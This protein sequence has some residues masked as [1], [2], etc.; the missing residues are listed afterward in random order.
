MVAGRQRQTESEVDDPL[1]TGPENDYRKKGS[2]DK[3]WGETP[4]SDRVGTEA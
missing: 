4:S 3:H 2:A 1:R